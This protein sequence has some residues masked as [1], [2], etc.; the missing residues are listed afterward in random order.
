MLPVVPFEE[1]LALIVPECLRKVR[2]DLAREDAE[3]VRGPQVQPCTHFGGDALGDI[4][5]PPHTRADTHRHRQTHERKGLSP[6]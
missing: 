3:R 2:L 6:A 4:A 1:R 5:T